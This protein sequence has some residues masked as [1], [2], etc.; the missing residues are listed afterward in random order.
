MP[1]RYDIPRPKIRVPPTVQAYTSM[2]GDAL[3]ET[4][5]PTRC[6]V[7]DAPGETLCH[8]CRLNLPYIDH[9]RACPRCGAPF[10]RIQCT[11]CNDVMLN[12][13]GRE[14]V[15]FDACVCAVSLGVAS[16]R[17]VRTW[18]DGGERR[19]AQNM[20]DIM[21]AIAPP[22]W[23]AD[24]SAVT[25]VPASAAA[26]RQRGFDHGHLLA[27]AIAD[28]LSLPGIAVLTRPRSTDQR[29][30]SR[31]ARITNAANSLSAL[32]GA[33]VPQS[34]LLIDDVY[35]TGATL[36]NACDALHAAGART[37]RCLTFARA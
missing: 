10:G 15:P 18:K 5:W 6:A 21:V 25:F 28:R 27:S 11:E 24:I 7:C 34:L 30:L 36:Y 33:S 3:V 9:W 17:I 16:S 13:S 37:I 12:A 14:E 35:T 4:L 29:I 22:D 32:A 23:T 19:L 2:I 31:K 20:A 1:I 26:L 8:S